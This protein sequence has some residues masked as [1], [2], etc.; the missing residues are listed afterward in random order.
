[1]ALDLL[2]QLNPVLAKVGDDAFGL[3]KFVVT[4]MN[5]TLKCDEIFWYFGEKALAQGSKD[6]RI[7][8][9]LNEVTTILNSAVEDLTKLEKA[10]L[11]SSNVLSNIKFEARDGSIVTEVRGVRDVPSVF[12][13]KSLLYKIEEQKS[14]WATPEIPRDVAMSMFTDS[15]LKSLSQHTSVAA[16][17]PSFGNNK[18]DINLSAAESRDMSF[19]EKVKR[20]RENSKFVIAAA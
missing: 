4:Q 2:K 1:M 16:S 8:K 19:A 20:Q 15:L 7:N 18:V 3:A 17:V 6:E 11:F 13:I 14:L 12:P 9:F 5:W 10:D